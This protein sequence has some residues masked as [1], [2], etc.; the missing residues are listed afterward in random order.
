MGRWVFSA[1]GGF[2]LKLLRHACRAQRAPPRLSQQRVARVGGV[3]D[4]VQALR[5]VM[6]EGNEGVKQ[7]VLK[8]LLAGCLF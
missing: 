1:L 5:A 7:A 8:G 2:L 3:D 4:E 6:A